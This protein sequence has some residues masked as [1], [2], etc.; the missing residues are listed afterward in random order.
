[1][2]RRAECGNTLD[3]V[4]LKSKLNPTAQSCSVITSI[5][6][7]SHAR[8]ENAEITPNYSLASSRWQPC[9]YGWGLPYSC[10]ELLG[11]GVPQRSRS[12]GGLCLCVHVDTHVTA[13]RGLLTWLFHTE[14]VLPK[15]IRPYLAV[16][17]PLLQSKQK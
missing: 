11:L 17:M 1:M 8:R 10:S 14:G 4:Y 6:D 13:F 9:L 3:M 7:F 2:H 12:T 5:W 15:I 16:L